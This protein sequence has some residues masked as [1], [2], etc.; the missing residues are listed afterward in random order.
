MNAMTSILIRIQS[1]IMVLAFALGAVSVA[2]EN[3]IPEECKTGGF[4]IG[5]IAYTFDRFTLLESLE[6]TAE[7]GGKVVE[8]CAKTKLSKEEP[9]VAFDYHASAQ[10]V[11]KVKDKLA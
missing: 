3:R 10:T 2:A 1:P 5:C 9:N 8:L 4:N 7:A 6:K 11:Q